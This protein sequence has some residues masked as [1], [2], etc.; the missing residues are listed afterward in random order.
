MGHHASGEILFEVSE[1]GAGHRLVREELQ[2]VG[3]R[4]RQALEEAPWG[5]GKPGMASL[6]ES[7]MQ[8]P[9]SPSGEGETPLAGLRVGFFS[10]QES[11][12]SCKPCFSG[13]V[14]LTPT[15]KQRRRKSAALLLSGLPCRW[16]GWSFAGGFSPPAGW[17]ESRP[18]LGHLGQLW[19]LVISLGV[20]SPDVLTFGAALSLTG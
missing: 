18:D 2:G 6:P 17:R 15:M 7:G 19:L 8:V 16:P 13:T 14:V 12:A 1:S 5:R 11:N 20:A 9:D 10:W 3:C 4:Q